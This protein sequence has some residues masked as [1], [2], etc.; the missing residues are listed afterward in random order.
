M[1]NRGEW[2]DSYFMLEGVTETEAHGFVQNGGSVVAA[3]MPGS[4]KESGSRDVGVRPALRAYLD[5]Q[6]LACPDTILIEELGLCQGLARIDLATVSG[7][8]HGYEIKSNRDRL[9][10]LASQAET[11]SR[12]FDRVTLVVGTKHLKAA[13]Q[14][15]PRWWGVLL[16]RG[17][18]EGVS[19]NPF[20]T[21]A[22][23]P[24]QDP[25]ALVELLWRDEAL[26]LLARH[27]AAA[28]V[29]SKP[30]P[31]VWDRVC[32]VLDLAQIRSAVRYRLRTRA[33]T[34][35]FA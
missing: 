7:V 11:Y 13:L 18:I 6:Q 31:A 19:L 12:V 26:E 33:A 8:L 25:R 9:S 22:E 5:Q 23:N 14:L 4:A 30:R 28:G 1:A 15:V 27:D 10:R 32:E 2:K 34:S 3:V 20:R 24:G 17:D 16:V 29:R 21:A 35:T